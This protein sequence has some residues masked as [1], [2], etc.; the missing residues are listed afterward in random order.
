MAKVIAIANNKGGVGK[1][2]TAISLASLFADWNLRVALIDNDPQGN[3]GVYLGRH[4][5]DNKHTI[6]DMYNGLSLKK[7]GTH[8][9]FRE[10]L[11]PQGLEFK[12][13]NLSVFLSNQHLAYVAEDFHRIGKLTEA[14]AE[15]KNDYD[16]V[17]VDNGPYIGYLTRAA[18]LAADMVLIP[19]EAGAGGLAGIP[20]IIK[21]AETINARHWRQVII[22]I[23]VNNF[24]HTE[25]FDMSNLRKLKSMVGDRLYGTY[26]PAN[27]HLR[28]SKELGLPITLLD[29]AAKTPIQGA[30]AYRILGK[31][32]LKDLLPEFLVAHAPKSVPGTIKRLVDIYRQQPAA[33]IKKTGPLVPETLLPVST[34]MGAKPPEPASVAAAEIPA[35]S[36]RPIGRSLPLDY[37]HSRESHGLGNLEP[38]TSAFSTGNTACSSRVIG[39]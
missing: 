7:I 20:Q 18:L 10:T 13:E 22:R 31:N 25:D 23:F 6:A 4:V 11:R 24:Q 21:E 32:I 29:K 26:I 27:I 38:R 34:E 9:L 36:S 17:I 2:T 35:G 1:T 3:V 16:L 19:T 5:F 39:Q 15:I 37:A 14:L 28:K 8:T 12:Q 30:L 33:Q